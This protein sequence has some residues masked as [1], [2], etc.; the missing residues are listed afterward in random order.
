LLDVLASRGQPVDVGELAAAVGLHVT[1]ARVHLEVLARAGLVARAAQQ[2]GGRPGRPRQL[3]RIVPAPAD[4]Q[5]HRPLA[6]VLAA[7][8]TD[9]LDQG[10]ERAERAGARWADQEISAVSGVSWEQA[11][12]GVAELFDRLGFAPRLVDAGGYRHVE[13]HACPFRDTARAY[14]HVVCSVHL[15]LLRGALARFGAPAPGAALRPFVGPELCIADLP[16]PAT[17]T[18]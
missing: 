8:V 16:V 15:G 6:A 12:R 2:H 13:L 18:E 17:G 9:D 1:T 5:G 14:P 4:A 7:A 10:R 3:Y 11:T